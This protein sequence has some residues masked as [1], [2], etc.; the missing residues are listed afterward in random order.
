MFTADGPWLAV[1]LRLRVGDRRRL[2]RSR[3]YASMIFLEPP[4]VQ[5]LV[6]VA[7]AQWGACVEGRR[8][9]GF[10]VDREGALVRRSSI[11]HGQLRVHDP[12]GMWRARTPL[13]FPSQVSDGNG[14][15]LVAGALTWGGFLSPPIERRL[16][17]PEIFGRWGMEID[18]VLW[19]LRISSEG[20]LCQP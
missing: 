6:V 5:I 1:A 14:R 17:V 10:H 4:A 2:C 13:V 11:I 19:T 12:W 16:A 15:K 18:T 8:G 20:P 7:N 9:E 3:S